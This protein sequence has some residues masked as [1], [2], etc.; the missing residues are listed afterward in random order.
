MTG[1]H[2]LQS[3]KLR[4]EGDEAALFGPMADLAALIDPPY[5][6]QR[7][8][9]ILAAV[10]AMR[11][12][13]L[14][15]NTQ[16]NLRIAMPEFLLLPLIHPMRQFFEN[17]DRHLR[18]WA[19]AE[20]RI[21]DV[22]RS[23]PQPLLPDPMPEHAAR[24]TLC[25]AGDRLWDRVHR[26]LSPFAALDH[27][28]A[29][30]HHGDIPYNSSMFMERMQAARRLC[31]AMGRKAPLSFLDVGSG[32]SVKVL[33]AAEF[34][35]RAEGLEYEPELAAIGDRLVQGGGYTGCRV[36]HGDALTFD[37]YGDFDVIYAYKPMHDMEMLSA[38][39]ARI[40][41]QARPGTILVMP[42]SDFGL[43]AGMLGCK[44]LGHMIYMAKPGP[45]SIPTLIRTAGHVGH[46][47]PRPPRGGYPE[48]GFV[49]PLLLR[50]RHW[51]HID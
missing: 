21:R 1:M 18:L 48:A 4:C 51:G 27:Q 46:H 41:A 16:S 33:Q 44:P 30:G 35:E 45:R 49:Q 7:R 36:R 11:L 31:L 38:M 32:V 24:T 43:R 26:Y 28:Q 25:A 42:Y 22:V 10:E 40:V 3:L 47:L 15:L 14:R 2:S 19:M 23:R 5:T 12:A 29:D 17:V 6:P 39:E 9:V 20:T 34:F 50:L 8:A 13:V 37:G